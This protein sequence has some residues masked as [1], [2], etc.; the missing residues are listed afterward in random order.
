MNSNHTLAAP[1]NCWKMA[2]NATTASRN[3]T[4]DI[5]GSHRPSQFGRVERSALTLGMP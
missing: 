1:P 4:T 3:A 2:G 5:H